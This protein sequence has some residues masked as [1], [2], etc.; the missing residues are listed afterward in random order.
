M[1]EFRFVCFELSFWFL[2][3]SGVEDMDLEANC[4]VLLS[5]R[6]MDACW[7]IIFVDLNLL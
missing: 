3:V 7:F 4:K 5:E 1:L 2:F 6:S